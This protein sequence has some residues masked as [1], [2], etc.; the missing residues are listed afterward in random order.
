MIYIHTFHFALNLEIISPE[1]EGKKG[2]RAGT[3]AF[4]HKTVFTSLS[5]WILPLEGA[6]LYIAIIHS[7]LFVCL[8]LPLTV[9]D[10]PPEFVLRPLA[11][12]GNDNKK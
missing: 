3:A 6:S 4:T 9:Q 12:R 1:Y 11:K 7:N 5:L 2:G 10:H 8:S